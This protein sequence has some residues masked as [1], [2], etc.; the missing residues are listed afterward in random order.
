[1]MTTPSA[2]IPLYRL[3]VGVDI[4]AVTAKAA[5]LSPGIAVTRPITMDQTSQGFTAL[6]QQLLATGHPA[7]AILVAMEAT[8]A[9]WI[10]LATALHRA[11]FAVCVIN[12]AQAHH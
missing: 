6:Q 9:Y 7:N 5:W 3:F 11:G 1:M 10:N 2:P 8:G 4:A 12:P